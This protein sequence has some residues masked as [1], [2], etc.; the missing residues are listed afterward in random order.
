MTPHNGARKGA[1]LILFAA[2]LWGTTGTAQTFLP[3]S[4][5]SLSLGAARLAI[6]SLA[7]VT[8]VLL[9]GGF[10]LTAAWSW[11]LAFLAGAGI[12]ISQLSFL[13]G[14]RLTGVA[15]GTMVAM[16]SAPIFSGLMDAFL[17]KEHF[18]R[19]WYLATLLSVSGILLLA[20]S[21]S[22][23]LKTNP[24][25]ILL[26]MLSGFSYVVMMS[27]NKRLLASHPPLTVLAVDSSIA[28]LLVFPLFFTLDFSWLATPMGLGV[29]L[30]LGLIT[31]ALTHIIFAHGLQIVSVH[32]AATLTLA[33]PLTAALLGILVVGEQLN[34]TT[35]LGMALIFSGLL[36]LT[37]Y[38][39][40]R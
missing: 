2:V 12:A 13:S 15:V 26:T 14:V 10:H 8:I 21:F 34:L 27:A 20:L 5:S 39:P 11:R 22:T 40:R 3:A 36:I 24:L 37:L 18:S 31:S 7:L 38:S 23:D 33:E 30:Y 35:F 17:Q 28:V 25:G 29:A 16:G 19:S 32:N 6:S 4:V 1:F 9:R